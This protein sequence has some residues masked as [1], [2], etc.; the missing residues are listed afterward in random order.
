VTYAHKLQR[1][2]GLLDWR[3]TAAQ[4]ANQVRAYDPTPGCAFEHGGHTYKVWAAQAVPAAGAAVGTARA[5]PAALGSVLAISAAGVDIACGEAALDLAN[6]A[7]AGGTGS[8]SASLGVLRITEI[9]KAGG[10]RLPVSACWQHL[11]LTVA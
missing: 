7:G 3:K 8:T 5:R 10:K 9:Q 6:P 4:L 11:G 1:A 2:D